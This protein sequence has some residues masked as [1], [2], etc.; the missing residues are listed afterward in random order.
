MQIGLGRLETLVGNN[1]AARRNYRDALTA[2]KQMNDLRGQ[3]NVQLEQ[4]PLIPSRIRRERRSLR[5]DVV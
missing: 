1:D 2:Y 4:I 3:A 5:I